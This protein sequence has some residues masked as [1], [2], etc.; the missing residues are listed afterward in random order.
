MVG[1]LTNQNQGFMLI[2]DLQSSNV[3]DCV[4]GLTN[5][6][7]AGWHGW[8][9]WCRW[10]GWCRR[11]RHFLKRVVGKNQGFML[12]SD[13]DS[14]NVIGCGGE[15]TQSEQGM[16]GADGVDGTKGTDDAD[17][18]DGVD[19]MHGMDTFLRGWWGKNQ[20]FM[21]IS[22]LQSSHVIGCGGELNQSE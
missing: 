18:M 19:G 3:I 6:N 11:H 12:L 7:R 1:S 9:G 2:S 8:H 15:F 14:S 16:D 13:L 4:V 21:L 22:D 17:S 5:Q 10:C 20:G